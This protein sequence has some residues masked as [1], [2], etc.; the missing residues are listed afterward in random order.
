MPVLIEAI[1]VV[2]RKDAIKAKFPGGWPALVAGV[3]NRTLCHDEDIARVG[4][5]SPEDVRSYV[6]GLECSGLQYLVDGEAHDL[7]VV[8]QEVG[9][10]VSVGWLEIAALP[11][12]EV[13]GTVMA[14][15]LYGS[16][17]KELFA[18]AHWKFAG[19][20]SQNGRLVSAEAAGGVRNSVCEAVY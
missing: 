19:S 8:D 5:M 9:I 10:L 16:D 7:A 20:M 3:P 11:N 13:G 6:D 2:V 4:F 17:S 18:P 15:R 12:E 14:C 1:S